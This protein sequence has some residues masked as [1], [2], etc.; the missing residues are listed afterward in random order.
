MQH[1]VVQ[2]RN[3]DSNFWIELVQVEANGEDEDEIHGGA[4]GKQSVI[5][6]RYVAGHARLALV[7]RRWNLRR[8]CNHIYIG[9]R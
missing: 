9:W 4:L 2:P 7:Y 3:A 6:A 1:V 8:H 5:V